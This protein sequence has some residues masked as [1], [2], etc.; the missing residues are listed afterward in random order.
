MKPVKP[1]AL[2]AARRLREQLP[3]ISPFLPHV[4]PDL[5][6]VVDAVLDTEPKPLEDCDP[7]DVQAMVDFERACVQIREDTD[8]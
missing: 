7:R 3:R 2:E 6:I 8:A 5:E 1:E 4:A